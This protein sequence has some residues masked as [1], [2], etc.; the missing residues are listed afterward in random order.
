[1][2]SRF[3]QP[4]IGGIV[5]AIATGFTTFSFGEISGFKTRELLVTSIPRLLILCFVI[6]LGSI[7]ILGIMLGFLGMDFPKE[8]KLRHRYCCLLLYIQKVDTILAIT[9][10]IVLL[11]V[12]IPFAQTKIIPV[13]WYIYYSILATAS[14]VGGVFIS[15]IIMI[16]ET[17]AMIIH[18]KDGEIPDDE[19]EAEQINEIE[20]EK[21][22]EK[23][24]LE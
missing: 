5:F 4:I 3:K 1:M 13:S 8:S 16:Y 15:I 18:H 12:N 19:P 10:I 11:L 2:L 7:S 9:A 22:T 21:E 24:R 20:K 23:W 17:I 6:I 14:I